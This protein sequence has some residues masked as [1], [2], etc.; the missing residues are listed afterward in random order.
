MFFQEIGHRA[1][2]RVRLGQEAHDEIRDLLSNINNY[3]W[4]AEE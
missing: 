2:G 4:P 3:Y 1:D